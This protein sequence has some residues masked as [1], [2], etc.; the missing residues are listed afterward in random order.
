MMI[1]HR[2]A[3]SG[4]VAAL[5]LISAAG[6]GGTETDPGAGDAASTTLKGGGATTT[7]ASLTISPDP[8]DRNA[9]MT[10]SLYPGSFMTQSLYVKFV[11]YQDGYMDDVDGSYE[12]HAASTQ[13]FPGYTF[14]GDHFSWS[15]VLSA[16]M[17]Y[18]LQAGPANCNVTGWAVNKRQQWSQ[19]ATGT[20]SVQ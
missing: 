4:L 12:L 1:A 9:P 20:F 10:I 11:C 3:M 17:N 15:F 8:V 18:A 14:D 16:G 7:P 19:I 13:A 5:V 2:A 6:C